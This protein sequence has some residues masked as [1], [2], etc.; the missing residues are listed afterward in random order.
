MH[1]L[2]ITQSILDIALENANL[3]KAKKITAVNLILGQ[4]TSMIDESIQF[5]WDIL[6]EG[7][8]AQGAIIN[9]H[10]IPMEMKCRDC[11][12]EF[13]PKPDRFDCPECYSGK[14]VIIK[15]EEMKIDSIDVE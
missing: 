5:Y 3:S 8:K 11:G 14:I 13:I 1:E 12:I 4:L 6:S 9:I 15:G 7:T 2:T 10:R